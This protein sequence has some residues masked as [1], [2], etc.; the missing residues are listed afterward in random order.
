MTM[1]RC[2]FCQTPV[3]GAGPVALCPECRALANLCPAA[4]MPALERA[5][6]KARTSA[7]DEA[8]RILE[9][10]KALANE[11]GRPVSIMVHPAPKKA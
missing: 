10:T 6:A 11:L 7:P 4:V 8:D 5:H 9:V 3:A 2:A 1:N